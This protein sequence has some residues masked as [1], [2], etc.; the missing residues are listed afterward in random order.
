M[1]MTK[2]PAIQVWLEDDQIEDIAP[3]MDKVEAAAEAGAPGML[4]AQVLGD[5]LLVFF[6]TNDQAQEFQRVMGQR[7]GMTTADVPHSAVRN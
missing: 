4:C 3:M 6:L 5:R 2:I 1:T 7:V